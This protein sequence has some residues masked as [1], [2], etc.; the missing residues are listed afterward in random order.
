MHAASSVYLS[1]QQW[2]W[3]QNALSRASCID[4]NLDHPCAH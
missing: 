3:L 2:S 1:M 4:L